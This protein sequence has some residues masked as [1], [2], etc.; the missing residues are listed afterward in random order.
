MLES[1]C[2]WRKLVTGQGCGYSWGWLLAAGEE[3]WLLLERGCCWNSAVVVVKASLMLE[4]NFG[5]C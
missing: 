3:P 5:C 1:G 4:Q 2:C